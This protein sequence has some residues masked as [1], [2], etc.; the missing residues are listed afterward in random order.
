MGI[1]Q[2]LPLPSAIGTLSPVA[3]VSIVTM[4]SSATVSAAPS[5][6]LQAS[7]A[8]I[9][10]AQRQNLRPLPSPSPH[11]LNASQTILPSWN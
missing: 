1:Y 2:S 8:R 4:L 5:P 11:Y 3:L 9:S 10:M 7:L 6:A